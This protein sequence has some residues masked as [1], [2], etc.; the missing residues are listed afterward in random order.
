MPD[1][2]SLSIVVPVYNSEAFL[3]RVIDALLEQ[4]YPADR[5]EI[6]LVDNDSTDASARI[7]AHAGNG[8]RLLTESKP[9]AYACRNRG[10]T[11]SSG[12]IVAFTDAD[13]VAA[14]DWARTIAA[15]MADPRACVL[16]GRT[17]MG[18]AAS[19]NLQLL[20]GYEHAKNQY[21]LTSGVRTMYYGRT[22]NMAVRRTLLERYPLS[23]AVA[24]AT[25]SS[26]DRWSTPSRA[27]P[28]A[29]CPRCASTI[30]RSA[31]QAP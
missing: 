3:E 27:L 1:L 5:R 16:I 9:G 24:A 23:N 12:S 22:N 25:R 6:V 26:C 17:T 30:S 10:V 4:D 21:A 2:P 31:T 13:C 7:A 28:S 20:D 11:A 14:P 15:Q 18:D 19:R 29:M 8:V